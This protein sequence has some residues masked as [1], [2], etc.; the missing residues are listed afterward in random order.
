MTAATARAGIGYFLANRVDRAHGK[1]RQCVVQEEVRAG[2]E[3]VRGSRMV[4]MARQGAW[5]KWENV[6]QHVIT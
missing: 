2:V 3:E 5:T 4:G 1:Q 6:L